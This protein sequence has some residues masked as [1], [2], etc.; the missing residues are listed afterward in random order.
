MASTR[1]VF[2]GPSTDG[3]DHSYRM[4]VVPRYETVAVA[5]QR[6]QTLLLVYL[7]VG[8]VELVIAASEFAAT[9][10]MSAEDAAKAAS[11]GSA[12][13]TPSWWTYT[14]PVLTLLAA[15]VLRGTLRGTPGL[16][17]LRSF[18]VLAAFIAV[19]SLVLDLVPALNTAVFSY[20]GGRLPP[21][22]SLVVSLVGAGTLL[23]GA[24]NANFAITAIKPVVKAPARRE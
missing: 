2:T 12:V 8:L 23:L 7:A 13:A 9:Q 20:A 1:K 24:A 17:G 14:K 18:A 19:A 3:S 21:V 16:T 11:A 6:L 10:G 5:S 4:R 15:A 22:V